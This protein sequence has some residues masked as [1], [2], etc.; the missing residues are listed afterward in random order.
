MGSGIDGSDLCWT[1]LGVSQFFKGGLEG[2]GAF[3]DIV[4]CSYL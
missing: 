2:R 4:K 3:A 1:T